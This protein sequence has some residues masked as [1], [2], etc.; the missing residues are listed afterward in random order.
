VT[1]QHDSRFDVQ[2]LK[3]VFLAAGEGPTVTL[4]TLNPREYAIT[5][6]CIPCDARIR[7]CKHPHH[8]LGV[9]MSG[10]GGG[11]LVRDIEKMLLIVAVSRSPTKCNGLRIE[12][13]AID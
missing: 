4:S 9:C 11:T 3:L 10:V 2:Q 12:Q 7:A 13:L 6:T 5:H 8:W 1:V